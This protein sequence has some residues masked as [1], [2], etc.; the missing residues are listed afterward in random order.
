MT[1][2]N[3]LQKFVSKYGSWNKGR[4]EQWFEVTTDE[5]LDSQL[6]SYEETELKKLKGKAEI[7][8]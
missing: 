1:H 4:R 5:A 8:L 7:Q 2:Q 3:A 6:K